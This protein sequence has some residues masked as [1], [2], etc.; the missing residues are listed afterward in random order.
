LNTKG[1]DIEPWVSADGELLIFSSDGRPDTRGAY[2]LYAS[3][4]CGD[5]W[6]DPRNLGDRVNS[7]GWEFGGRPTPDGRR[8]L[9]IARRAYPDCPR[10][11]AD[12]DRALLEK[13]R[14]PG[15]GLAHAYGVEMRSLDLPGCGAAERTPPATRDQAA[16]TSGAV[17]MPPP[18]AASSRRRVSHSAGSPTG[19][20]GTPSAAARGAML[21]TLSAM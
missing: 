11:H 9:S 20:G 12:H 21:A 6:T 4:R 19:G 17:R 14:G 7:R 1:D 10:A 13:P 5:R 2:D 8:L 16:T 3:R 18:A 15:T